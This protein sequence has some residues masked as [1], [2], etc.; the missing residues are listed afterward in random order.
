MSGSM[1]AT[2]AAVQ[3]RSVAPRVR[4][5]SAC[6]MNGSDRVAPGRVLAVGFA[7]PGLEVDGARFL[8]ELAFAV[9][10]EVPGKRSRAHD[11][12]SRCS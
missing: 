11:R 12:F 1:T 3:A 4:A 6:A 5:D 10:D 8:S 7:V 2:R 9:V